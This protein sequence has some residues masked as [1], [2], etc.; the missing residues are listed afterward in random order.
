LEKGEIT[1]KKGEKAKRKCVRSVKGGRTSQEGLAPLVY[2]FVHHP[3]QNPRR[4]TEI[5]GRRGLVEKKMAPGPGESPEERCSRREGGNFQRSQKKKQLEEKKKEKEQR[6]PLAA[7]GFAGERK[8]RQLGR[9]KKI[10]CKMTG[11]GWRRERDETRGKSG[12]P[13]RWGGEEILKQ[14]GGK[15][16]SGKGTDR[17]VDE[18]F[19]ST[20]GIKK[21]KRRG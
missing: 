11:G 20:K 5:W 8:I 10:D 7:A 12:M 4:S 2:R 21:K 9:R 18:V 15:R 16:D 3:T 19:L 6:S 14:D 13:I 1:N 17:T